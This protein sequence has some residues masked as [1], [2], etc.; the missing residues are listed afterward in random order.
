MSD[1]LKLDIDKLNRPRQVE[2]E[3][4]KLWS[5]P[6]PYDLPQAVRSR[7][8]DDHR[9]IVIEFDYLDSETERTVHTQNAWLALRVGKHSGRI[10]KLLIDP[11]HLDRSHESQRLLLAELERASGRFGDKHARPEVAR[12][13]HLEITNSVIA[14]HYDQL[15]ATLG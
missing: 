14:N 10:L 5:R 12:R 15:A 7:W 1:W 9:H 8:S 13:T 2:F 4:Q 6:S 11:A 3:G